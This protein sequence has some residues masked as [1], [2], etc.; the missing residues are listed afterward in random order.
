MLFAQQEEKRQRSNTMDI[1]LD[2]GSRSNVLAKKRVHDKASKTVEPFVFDY[3]FV[4]T[5]YKIPANATHID[6]RK[7]DRDAVDAIIEG[8]A[9]DP[10]HVSETQ[11]QDVDYSLT[12]VS[13][14]VVFLQFGRSQQFLMSF[15][16]AFLQFVREQQ[17]LVI[18]VVVL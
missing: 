14:M 10:A 1:D 6:T 7:E 17:Y 8:W 3:Y 11:E 2:G 4:Q 5:F 12:V 15:M 13:F 16:V 18:F 9:E